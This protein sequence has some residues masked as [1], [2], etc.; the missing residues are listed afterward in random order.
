MYYYLCIRCVD[1]GECHIAQAVTGQLLELVFSFDTDGVHGFTEWEVKL[2]CL[3]HCLK[4]QA[5]PKLL[6]SKGRV[7]LPQNLLCRLGWA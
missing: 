6:P 4:Q 1:T 5:G 2:I 7:S 3:R